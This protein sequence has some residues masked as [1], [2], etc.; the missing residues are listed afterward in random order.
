MREHTSFSELE[1]FQ[2]CRRLWWYTYEQGWAPKRDATQLRRGAW[3]HTLLA[4]YYAGRDW[5]A[6]H[7]AQLAA[8]LEA[9]LFDEEREALRA[10]ADLI[11]GVMERYVEHYA[12]ERWEVV[13]YDGAPLVERELLITLPSGRPLKIKVDLV[14]RDLESE[15]VWVWDHK[16][17]QD[18]DKHMEAE[19]DY[20]P[21]LSIYTLGLRAL[22]LPVAG[23]LHNFLRMR[24]PAEPR[25]NKDGTM[26]RA[27]IITDEP[28]VRRF[29]ARSG[30]RI[31][32]AELL[33][34]LERLPRDAFFRRYY[35]VRSDDELASIAA[36][37]EAKL[38]ERELARAHGLYTRTL[39]K[40][41]VRCPFFGPCLV[42]LKGGDEEAVLQE[43][44][45]RQE[46]ATV[47]AF[48]PDLDEG[49]EAA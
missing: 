28:T 47:A 7:D 15:L 34:Y 10:E 43:Q 18:F 41:C 27:P 19:T 4:A 40:E 20:D 13:E 35:T 22:S 5:R 42:S 11:A 8:V 29:I 30:V 3:V 36:E 32:D 16:T 49:G 48:L 26:S 31:D 44:Y 38:D 24:L 37:I 23:G 45:A 12:D 1:T 17:R 14:A 2:R 33:A 9:A 46:E 25:L 21:Q 6:E 39:I